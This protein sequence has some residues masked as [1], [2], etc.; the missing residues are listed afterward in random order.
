MM[1]QWVVGMVG[2]WRECSIVRIIGYP[3]KKG[4]AYPLMI[5]PVMRFH[6]VPGVPP[7]RLIVILHEWVPVTMAR[8]N[9]GVTVLWPIRSF[10]IPRDLLKEY[11]LTNMS[12]S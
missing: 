5:Y 8:L 6:H 10:I 12:L 2:G 11:D 3:A 9:L 4:D 7:T 1:D